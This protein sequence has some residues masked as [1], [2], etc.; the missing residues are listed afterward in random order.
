M[1]HDVYNSN[2]PILTVKDCFSAKKIE[3]MNESFFQKPNSNPFAFPHTQ[4]PMGGGGGGAG[5]GAAPNQRYAGGKRW[6]IGASAAT[7]RDAQQF[8]CEVWVSRL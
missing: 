7:H 1:K 6:G 3:T 5:G 2:G 4:G 8:Y